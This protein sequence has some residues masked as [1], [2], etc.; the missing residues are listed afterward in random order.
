MGWAKKAYFTSPGD[1]DPDYSNSDD[2]FVDNGLNQ[3]RCGW[4]VGARV[5]SGLKRKQCG[6]LLYHV[7]E[8]VDRPF[9]SYTIDRLDIHEKIK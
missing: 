6:C 7:Y 2:V 1:N 9:M 8:D 4:L 5:C 3:C